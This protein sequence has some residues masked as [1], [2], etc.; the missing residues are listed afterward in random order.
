ML[1]IM[2]FFTGVKATDPSRSAIEAQQM[3]LSSMIVPIHTEKS[4]QCLRR[5]EELTCCNRIV[6]GGIDGNIDKGLAEGVEPSPAG[7]KGV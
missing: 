4:R 6:L 3:Q 2:S 1:P 5:L 7:G